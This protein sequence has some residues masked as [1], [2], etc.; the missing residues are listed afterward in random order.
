MSAPSGDARI[1]F[2]T[3]ASA[4]QEI[5][6]DE[7]CQVLKMSEEQMEEFVTQL[8]LDGSANVKLDQVKRVVSV[9][10]SKCV[11]IFIFL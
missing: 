2:F 6:Y 11:F 5:P 7:L 3:L 8:I 4:K 1:E 9:L 10:S